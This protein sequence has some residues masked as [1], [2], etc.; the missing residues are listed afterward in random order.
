MALQRTQITIPFVQGIDRKT[1]EF[2]IPIGKFQ[3]LDNSVFDTLGMM[4]KRNGFGVVC[5]LSDTNFLTTFKNNLLG[6]GTKVY[7]YNPGANA[8]FAAGYIQ[9]LQLLLSKQC[10]LSYQHQQPG[11]LYV[12]SL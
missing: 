12:P 10:R 3:S 8:S 5:S 9:P 4:K 1:D 2:Q 7:A 6:V 11:V